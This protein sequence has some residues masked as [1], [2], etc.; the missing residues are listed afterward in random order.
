MSAAP[1]AAAVG[2][3]GGT[4]DPVH[5]G[6]LEVAERVREL[7]DLPRMLLLPTARPPHK[8][9]AALSPA[10][11]REAMLR[12][13]LAERR[14]LEI[15]TLEMEGERV[16]FTIESLRALRDGSPPCRPVFVL[17]M[18]SL[19]ELESWRDWRALLDE[20]DLAV[21]DR[22]GL[23]LEV[24]RARLSPAVAGRL[25]RLP[26]PGGSGPAELQ[27]GRGGRVFH[28][29]LASIPIS[30]R[31]IRARAAAGLALDGLVPPAVARYIL[32]SGLYRLPQQE[33]VR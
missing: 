26:G 24:A 32:E 18:D 4:F 5:S 31:E 9:P 13:A 25:V 12:L 29:P 19:L 27:P 33:D 21:I 11:H 2:V 15:C 23:D 20:F 14:A 6:H 17:G 22:P 16:S 28:L 8:L 10:R 7:L 30:S 3:L 1:A